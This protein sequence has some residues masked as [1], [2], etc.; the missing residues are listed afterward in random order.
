MPIV[1]FH[2]AG[3]RHS[4]TVVTNF[5][6]KASEIYA[7][8]LECPVDRVRAL[9]IPHDRKMV[10]TGGATPGPASVFFEF[11]V[12]EGRSLAQRQR[13]ASE[14]TDLIEKLLGVDLAVIRG[15]CIRVDPEDWCIGGRFAS[16]IRE[17]EIEQRKK[18]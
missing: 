10:A 11:I 2:S 5:L 1:R 3:L 14:F 17:S 9:Y 7:R 8:I 18:L 15:H 6:E 16:D 12:L 4:E 13:I